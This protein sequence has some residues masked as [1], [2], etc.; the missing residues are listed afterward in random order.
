M[1]NL[2]LKNFCFISFLWITGCAPTYTWVKPGAT[3]QDFYQAKSYCEAI[4][5]GA[6]PMDYS[7]PSSTTT[8]HS[9][10]VYGEN[11]GYG[12][13][14]GTSTT[15][16]NNMNQA[17]ANLGKSVRRQRMFNDCMRGQGFTPQEELSETPSDGLNAGK[18][19]D[20]SYNGAA[21]AREVKV[22]SKPTFESEAI[23]TLDKGERVRVL[24]VSEYGFW[25]KV[26][27]DG[28]GE[29]YVERHWINNI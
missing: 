14:S 1:I 9:G 17:F 16:N 19:Q 22:Y 12:S 8:F 26:N 18:G 2:K 28:L 20:L 25:L 3:S 5:T 4:A 27:Y 13:Y 15:Y 11:G 6:T 24:E 10:S 21:N 7:S 23:Y 29:G